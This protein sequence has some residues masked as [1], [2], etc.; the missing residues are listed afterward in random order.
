MANDRI[1]DALTRIR[2]AT[3]AHHE[4]VTIPHSA[5]VEGIVTLMK[6]EGYL[7]FVEVQT[8]PKS[9]Q[10]KNLSVGLKYK[11]DGDAQ[12][13]HLQRVSRPG[14]RVYTKTPEKLSVRS[15]LGIQILSTS[16][17]IISDRQAIERRLGGEVLAEIW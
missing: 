16:K 14:M 3:M 7:E 6:D 4:T 15:G 13:K 8:N 1:A 11:K 17:G 5:L 10:K 9:P 12:F 2:N